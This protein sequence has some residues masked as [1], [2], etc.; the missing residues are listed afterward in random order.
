[1]EIFR[2]KT[3]LDE[4]RSGLF[5]GYFGGMR[6]AAYDIETTGLTKERDRVIL[7]GFCEVSGGE[8]VVTQYMA[9]SMD[10]EAA[11]LEAALDHLSGLDMVLTYNGRTFDMPFT[12]GRAEKLGITA[13]RRPYDF[14][15]YPVAKRYTGIGDFTPNMRQ[16][17]LEN[18]MGLWDLRKDTI[19]GARSI[20]LFL[21]WLTDGDDAKLE[22]ILL[23]NHD[24]VLQLYR[25][26]KV[27]AMADIH[28]AVRRLGVPFLTGD[29]E[30]YT[31]RKSE[32]KN[33]SLTVEGERLDT[34]SGGV[35][36]IGYGMDGVEE[37]VDGDGSFRIR[38]PL[39][40]NCPLTLADIDACGVP[41]DDLEKLA[42]YGS[43]YLVLADQA[44]EKD[45]E[46]NLLSRLLARSA[47]SKAKGEP[48]NG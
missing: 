1:M 29:G 48:E 22:K 27:L 8:A 38:I 7:A 28:G 2:T 26:L 46:I 42:T 36:Y 11:V 12:Y 30:L 39:V 34:P 33:G 37:K 6:F 21:D 18:F 32:L 20:E 3:L 24:D 41:S 5:D 4:Y 31:V 10:D 9:E 16:T 45:M 23:H 17:T 35:P 44:G 25:L 19:D 40:E 43:G 14:D 47:T 13:G 15:L